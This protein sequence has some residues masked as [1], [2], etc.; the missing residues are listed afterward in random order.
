VTAESKAQ[1]AVDAAKRA[2]QEAMHSAKDFA[3]KEAQVFA[4]QPKFFRY[5]VYIIAAYAALIGLTVLTMIPR[6]PRN[7]LNAYVLAA[8]GDFILGTYILV[9]ND[10]HGD[11]HD[12]TFVVNGSHT[13]KTDWVVRGQSFPVKLKELSPPIDPNEVRDIRIDCSRGTEQYD[14][15][16]GAPPP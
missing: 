3:Q 6:T 2:A 12:V 13:L 1:V 8:R 11:W 5:R 10:S 4:A 16:Y 7:R 15:T 14:V 9:R